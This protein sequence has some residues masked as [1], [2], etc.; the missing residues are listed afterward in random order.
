MTAQIDGEG[1]RLDRSVDGPLDL[2]IGGRRVW[3]FT[4]HRDG[5]R[6]GNGVFVAWPRALVAL[7]DGHAE[8]EVV[9]HR[10]GDPVFAGTVR[11]GTS[12]DPL[13]LVDDLG[14]PLAVDRSGRLHRTFGDDADETRTELVAAA[15]GVL[16]D[17][18][19]ECGLDAYLGYGGL[20]G[21]ARS[22]RTI[23]HDSDL[24][25]AYLSRHTHPFDVIR[26]CRAAERTMIRRGW[27][28]VRMSA[29]GFKIWVPLPSGRQAGVDV[30]A[31]FHVGDHFH[32]AGSLRGRLD[33]SALVPF[34]EIELEGVTFPAPADV[35]AF[36]AFTYGTRWRTPDPAFRFDHPP[37]N[38]RRMAHW[39]RGT[40]NRLPH[41]QRFYKGTH[42]DVPAE[43]SP[44]AAWAQER[45][46]PGDPIVELGSGTGRDAIWFAQQGHPVTG[47]DFCGVARTVASTRAADAGMRI[48][49]RGLNVESLHSSL[50]GAARI[51]HEPEPAH[52]YAR[53]LVDAVAGTGRLGLW[54]FC[55]LAGRR[56]GL[57]FLEFRTDESR[58]MPTYF[59]AHQRTF[60]PPELIVAEIERY[61]GRVLEQE[62][63]RGLAPLGGEDPV[64]CRLVVSW[65]K[66]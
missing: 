31:S 23:G 9:P 16:D 25:L 35:A 1:I 54:R 43:R 52:L 50:V 64:V 29:A 17:L 49:F 6:S 5:I 10:G 26:E 21:A 51:A 30:F 65:R 55:A 44:F 15:R 40:R 46:E 53:G 33:R 41:W 8:V 42:L 13:R 62:I 58:T 36:L 24:D 20:L 38:V 19:D 59:D 12:T 39:F 57:T 37:E 2:R 3:S 63:G 18:V 56:G 47:S 48:G 28:V 60:A 32:V 61:G 27:Q 22:G 34:G 11:F 66:P 45:M 7:L 14:S 4:S